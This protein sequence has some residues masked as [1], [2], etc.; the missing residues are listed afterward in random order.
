MVT[1]DFTELSLD[2]FGGAVMATVTYELVYIAAGLLS[3]VAPV[4]MSVSNVP[5]FA[6][7]ASIC[8][9]GGAIFGKVGSKLYKQ[10]TA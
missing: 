3:S 9:L 8:A 6:G 5:I 2:I 1:I 7:V 4:I 10:A